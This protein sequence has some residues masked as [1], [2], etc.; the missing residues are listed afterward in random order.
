MK[1]T[2]KARYTNLHQSSGVIPSPLLEPPAMWKMAQIHE[3]GS[4]GETDHDVSSSEC[5]GLAG[6]NCNVPSIK[7]ISQNPCKGL[8]VCDVPE[9][10]CPVDDMVLEWLDHLVEQVA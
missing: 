9:F 6:K 8:S 5:P 4:T 2:H 10:Q 1:G 7:L 3:G